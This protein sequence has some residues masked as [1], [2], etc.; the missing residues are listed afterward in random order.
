MKF[1]WR[2]FHLRT[3]GDAVLVVFQYKL[4]VPKVG[5]ISDL[6]ISLS[7]LSG[8]PADKVNIVPFDSSFADYFSSTTKEKIL[9]SL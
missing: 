9:R 8:V 1:L 3:I 7:N 6:C 5:Y 2:R 4:T